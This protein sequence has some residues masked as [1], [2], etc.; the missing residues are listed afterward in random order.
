MAIN[1]KY[2]ESIVETIVMMYQGGISVQSIVN[3]I[4]GV[5]AHDVR[6]VLKEQGILSGPGRRPTIVENI[7]ESTMEALLADY[8]DGMPTIQI[9][10][11]YRLGR[12]DRIYMIL[13]ELGQPVRTNLPERVLTR[14]LQM[15]LAVDMYVAGIQIWKIVEETGIQQPALH[16]ELHKRRIPGRR[17]P[18]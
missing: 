10:D 6:R 13:R 15:D 3:E 9:V 1:E 4:E 18:M 11:K 12:I 17:N 5:T 14:K 7:D 8:Y 16:A 2:R